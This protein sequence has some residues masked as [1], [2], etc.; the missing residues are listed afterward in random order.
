MTRRLI[1]AG[2]RPISP[3]VDVTNY[4]MHELGQPQHAY[5]ADRIPDGRI[6][7][8]RARAGE[9][10]VTIDH[11]ER[12]LDDRMLVIADRERPIGLAGI[13]GGA[14]TEV[15]DAT[16]R[17]ILESAI[18][19]GPTVRNTARRLGLRSE[20]SMR[21]EKGISTDLPR[22]AADRAAALIAEITGARVATGIVDNDPGPHAERVV[23]V[24][25]TRTTRLLGFP[26][27]PA[28]MAGWLAPL[29]FAVADRGNDRA[30][31]TVPLYRQDVVLPADVAEEVARARGY[32]TVPSP[33]PAP[34]LP[35]HRP[36]PGSRR[37]A[38]RR[39]L[40][41]L[42]LD[43]VVTHA[44]IGPADLERSGFD[45]AADHLV[46]VANPLSEEHA[47]LR[48][49]PY[50]SVLAALA[51]NV[52]QRRT[53]VA[54]FEVGKT[55]RYRSGGAG[56]LAQAGGAYRETWNVGI[57]LLGEASPRFPGEPPRPWDVAD[58][59]GIVDAAHEAMGLPAPTYRPESAE[60]RHAHLHPGRAARMTDAAGKSYGSL[61]EVHPVVAGAWSLPGR[62][63]VAAIHLD[64]GGFF[65]LDPRS[66][67]AGPVPAAQ[68]VDRDLAVVVDAST[69][70]GEVLRLTRQNGG[71]LLVDVSL[72]D[73]YRGTQAG[74]GR[75]SYGIGLRF[76][77]ASAADEPAVARAM[78]KIGGALRHHLGA[79]IR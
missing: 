58:L 24:D 33:L 35:P 52:R 60:E 67:R 40:A 2:M 21:H 10:L 27:D 7:V 14:D 13:M 45:P 19:H 32:D 70:V 12:E 22:L 6:V 47:I 9:S 61:G 31:V 78:D 4:V 68:P 73:A 29:G 62:P 51:E 69:P 63:V 1:A 15:T 43:E 30:E 75:V 25:T 44:L 71:P 23:E 50:P 79:E 49:V 36:D 42:G 56:E 34:E 3:V 20:A 5:D 18:F 57:G 76:Q 77:P 48:P 16:R 64:P 46:R 59:K 53:D 37:H 66:Q 8:R 74:E 17:V 11:L 55:Y 72:F 26:V 28:G 65:A 39:V 54:L 41:G 38:L